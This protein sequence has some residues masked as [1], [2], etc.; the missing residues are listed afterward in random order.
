MISATE[1]D[2]RWNDAR[3]LLKSL[4]NEGIGVVTAG[5]SP[6]QQMTFCDPVD[7]DPA[8]VT[9]WSSPGASDRSE[10]MCTLQAM[11]ARTVIWA[12]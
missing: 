10:S 1:F 2:L 6:N 9:S 3:S 8:R 4:S 11:M 12:A 5:H 7:S